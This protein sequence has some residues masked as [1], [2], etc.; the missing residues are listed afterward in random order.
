[1]KY[2]TVRVYFKPFEKITFPLNPV[3]TLR[4]ALGYALKPMC[5]SREEKL[6]SNCKSCRKTVGCAYGTCF[7][8]GPEHVKK[9]AGIKDKDLPNLINIDAIF[10]GN[11]TFTSTD[12]FAFRITFLGIAVAYMPMVFVALGRAADGGLTFKRVKCQIDKIIDESDNTVLFDIKQA[13]FG[14]PNIRELN[15]KKPVIRPLISKEKSVTLNFI[16]PTAFKDKSS[17]KT[18]NDVSDF[19]RI[20]GSLMR[21]YTV[22]EAT[23]GK[24]LNWDFTAISDFAR[25]VRYVGS[26]LKTV[27]WERFSTNQNRTMPASGVVGFATY[28]GRLECF[29][30][31]LDAAEIIRCGKN[32]NFGQGRVIV[33]D[34]N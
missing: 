16:S 4:G 19:W 20:I 29:K 12:E 5:C 28:C 24:K 17:C 26:F 6:F 31:L 7:E 30:E 15:I 32:T 14:L 21:R 8:T 3:N 34:Y 27:E 11:S 10:E 9:S 1:M 23:E 33:E 22:F 13:T 2:S 18:L 25:N